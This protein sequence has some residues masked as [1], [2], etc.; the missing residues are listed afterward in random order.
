MT[1]RYGFVTVVLAGAVVA[2]GPAFAQTA[3]GSPATGGEPAWARAAETAAAMASWIDAA[4][5]GE[6]QAFAAEQQDRAREAADRDRERQDER[7]RDSA[8]RERAR[9]NRTY[10]EGQRYIDQQ[11]WDLAAARF[12]DVATMKG[13]KADAALYWKVYAQNRLGQRTEALATIASLAKDYPSSRYLKQASALEAEVRRD[14]GQPVRPQDENDEDLKL[15]ALQALQNSDPEQAIPMLEKLLEGSA[16]PRLKERALFVLAQSDSARARDLLT[17]YAKGSST[18]DLQSTAIKYLGIHGGK[19]SR[20]ALAEIYAGT[21][22]VEAKRQ[23]LRAFMIAGEKDRLL[24]AAQSEQNPDLRQE[25]VRQLGVMGAHEELWALYQ[26]ESSIDVKKQIL[27]AM[28]VGGNATRMIELARTEQNPE[29]RRTAV[30]NLGLMGDKGTAEA[31]VD[32]Y[33]RDKDVS[34]RKAVV[35]ALFIQDNAA[36]LV[37]LAR[38]EQDPVMKKDIVQ[39]LSN[40]RSKVAIDYM[41]EL[42]NAK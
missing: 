21:T 2:A 13:P 8:D 4:R 7:A 32:I 23:I 35:Q 19:E 41:L 37:S 1:S 33:G 18:P 17:S 25:A 9:E 24:T 6:W 38:K 34:I 11:K 26:K 39:K 3:T 22:D 42:L 27:Q 30:R 31:L 14:A 12:N 36:A 28:F 20:A 40:M 10:D 29:L 5:A 15:M 16:S